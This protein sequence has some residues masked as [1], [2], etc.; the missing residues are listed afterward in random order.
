VSVTKRK[1]NGDSVWVI[2]RRFKRADGTE[3]R[4][5][6]AAKVQLKAAA[7][8]EELDLCL[9]FKVKGTITHLLGTAVE[10]S[11]APSLVEQPAPPPAPVTKTYMWEDAVAHFGKNV[12]PDRKAS[13]RR[14]YQ[15]CLDGAY[16]AHFKG[17]R[18]VDIDYTAIENWDTWAKRLL[19]ND[20]SRRREHIVLHAVL[21]SVGPNRGGKWLMLERLPL[22]P[23]MPSGNKKQPP[24]P[25][26]EDVAMVMN[27][28]RDGG[29]ARQRYCRPLAMQRAQLAFALALWAGL[30][31]GEIRALRKSDIDQVRRIIIVRHSTS[32]GVEDTSKGE[33]ERTIKIGDLLWQ[34]LEPRLA[35]IKDP[36]GLVCLSYIGKPWHDLA[37][38]KAWVRACERVGVKRTK[39]HACRH[40]FLTKMFTYGASPVTV[41]KSAG[42]KDLKT[43]MKY[44]H[45][46]QD[47]QDRAIARFS[48]G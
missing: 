8:Q 44:A 4:Y 40:Y 1:V 9:E 29:V 22:F 11:V 45:F 25:T 33:D 16:L 41:M 30:R 31:A 27:E 23:A 10:P 43:T 19:P 6:R 3:E 12:L 47:D 39:F 14:N 7:N 13:T 34:R 24:I 21:R 2:D 42:H 46:E 37:I 20:G 35:E 36:N 5:R 26:A 38:C 28:G 32:Y 15:Q 17:R 18:L 48:T